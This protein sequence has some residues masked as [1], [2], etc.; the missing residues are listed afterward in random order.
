MDGL[1]K[2]YDKWNKLDKNEHLIWYHV[3]VESKKNTQPSG[4]YDKKKQ[5]AQ[6]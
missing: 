6:I 4:E 1:G 2:H 5:T 3:H